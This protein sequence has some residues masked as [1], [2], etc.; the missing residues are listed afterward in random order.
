MKFIKFYQRFVQVVHV[1]HVFYK[2]LIN[3]ILTR[4]DHWAKRANSLRP[5]TFS[6][7]KGPCYVCQQ[8]CVN[9]E[10]YHSKWL[11]NIQL[12][13]AK[14]TIYIY[15]L[16]SIKAFIPTDL[17]WVHLTWIQPNKN[18]AGTS[19]FTTA[20]TTT[21]IEKKAGC[22][23]FCTFVFYSYYKQVPANAFCPSQGYYQPR[24]FHVHS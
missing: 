6:C 13:H 22:F 12:S 15:I 21:L 8:V 14:Y 1:C 4:L 23:C 7:P 11:I 10:P 3:S 5:Q 19:K 17:Q 2:F 24:F 20:S 18:D 16:H 9:S